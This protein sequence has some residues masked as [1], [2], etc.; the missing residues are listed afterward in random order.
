[1]PQLSENLNRG[2]GAKWEREREMPKTKQKP[3]S[4]PGSK[5]MGSF[6]GAYPTGEH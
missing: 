2:R 4:L 3:H 5:L 1:M 6:L